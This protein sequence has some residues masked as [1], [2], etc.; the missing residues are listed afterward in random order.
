MHFLNKP[1]LLER[2]NIKY[3]AARTEHPCSIKIIS[4]L[5]SDKGREELLTEHAMKWNRRK[6]EGLPH[7]LSKH[8][9]KVQYVTSFLVFV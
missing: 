7:S 3:H 9:I 4:V 1:V 5:F 6:I 2:L 8:Y